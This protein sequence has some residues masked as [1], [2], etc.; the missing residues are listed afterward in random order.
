MACSAEW[1]SIDPDDIHIKGGTQRDEKRAK[2][3]EAGV[4]L[5]VMPKH[6]ITGP[7]NVKFSV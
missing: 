2:G 1:F 6:Y 4:I 7:R 5:S 3:K